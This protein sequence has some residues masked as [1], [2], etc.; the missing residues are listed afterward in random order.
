MQLCSSSIN[1]ICKH[2]YSQLILY[3][4]N[5]GELCIPEHGRYISALKYAGV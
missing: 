2:S 5:V 1:R 3:K 4:Y